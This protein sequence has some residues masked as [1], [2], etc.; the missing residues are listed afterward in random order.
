MECAALLVLNPRAMV[1]LAGTCAP[2]IAGEA[3]DLLGRE[4]WV[5]DEWCASRGLAM[6]AQDVFSGARSIL[7]IAVD[8]S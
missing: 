2:A 1:A 6:I 8:L 5:Y 3:G 7:G 4:V